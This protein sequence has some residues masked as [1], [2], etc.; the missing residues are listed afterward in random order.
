MVAGSN[1]AGRMAGS[2]GDGLGSKD[3]RHGGPSASAGP[4]PD[5]DAP[6]SHQAAADRA[7]APARRS[8]SVLLSSR[9]AS[10]RSIVA[11]ILESGVIEPDIDLE[12]G[13]PGLTLNDLVATVITRLDA[14]LRE[15]YGVDRPKCRRPREDPNRG[16]VPCRSARPRRHD[17]G[18][19]RGARSLQPPHSRHPRRS[20]AA[21]LAS[22]LSPFPE[23]LNRQLLV[24]N[25]RRSISHRPRRTRRTSSASGSLQN[26]IFVTGNTGIDALRVASGRSAPPSRIPPLAAAAGSGPEP[27]VVLTAHRRE[28]WGGGLCSHLPRPSR[29]SPS[30]HPEVHFRS[31]RSIPNPLVQASSSETPCAGL[32]NVRAPPSRCPMRRS[33]ASSLA[34]LRSCSPTQAGSRRRRRR[35][36]SPSSPRWR[37]PSVRRASRR[38]HYG[39]SAPIP[40]SIVEE[41]GRLLNNDA[42]WNAPASAPR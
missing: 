40:E 22:T 15:R 36:A 8:G 7:R 42:R 1:P 19:C 27:L 29:T 18:A 31:V 33:P 10:T 12:V 32:E 25:R 24:P 16:W 4:R 23:E 2:A 35:S 13:H 34:G 17:V 11:P 41:A 20:R 30:A 37:R 21:G 28:N 39:S 6:R 3:E 9:R 26:L 14:F 38:G 5:G